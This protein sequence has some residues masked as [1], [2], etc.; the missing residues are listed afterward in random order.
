MFQAVQKTSVLVRWFTLALIPFLLCSDKKIHSQSP[1]DEFIVYAHAAIC[2]QEVGE[3]CLAGV[4]I[5]N[6]TSG[7][8]SQFDLGRSFDVESVK[9]SPDNESF[10]FLSGVGLGVDI[11]KATIGTSFVENLTNL[12]AIYSSIRWSP[13]G[14]RILYTKTS[15]ETAT[16]RLFMMN[17]D[18]SE[19]HLLLE[20]FAVEAATWSPDSMQIAVSAYRQNNREG[21]ADI[22]VVNSDGTS[23]SSIVAA[24]GNQ[25]VS[26]WSPHG[27][28]ILFLS[29]NLE[30][31]FY[32]PHMYLVNL[33]TQRTERVINTSDA[34]EYSPQWTNDE[35][36]IVYYSDDDS[37][38]FLEL[39]VFD[40][41]QP[42][43]EPITLVD[44]Q[45]IRGFDLSPDSKY[46]V[47]L[48]RRVA[49]RRA[50]AQLCIVVFSTQVETCF[51]DA[52]PFSLAAPQWSN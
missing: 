5:L 37:N 49:G 26:Q 29:S 51:N 19:K 43:A 52:Q 4:E 8:V 47:Y 20:G 18:G 38:Q 12:P 45:E 1:D 7:T 10:L 2:T 35:R 46:L 48:S 39:N 22:Y 17:S 23:I 16:P 11:F 31:S 9:I 6:L 36:Y 25:Q 14:Q 32:N 28:Q 30:S 24:P 21:N 50:T 34:N 40:L 3:E 13:D 44:N 15:T 33:D 41:T 27:S 42:N